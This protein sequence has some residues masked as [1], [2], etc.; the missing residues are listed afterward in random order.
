MFGGPDP[1]DAPDATLVP[2][3][4]QLVATLQQ[5]SPAKLLADEL[6]IV[7]AIRDLMDYRPETL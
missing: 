4:A 3:A 5:V 7:H 6:E 2:M 1:V